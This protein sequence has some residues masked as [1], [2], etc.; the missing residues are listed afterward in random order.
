MPSPIPSERK[1]AARVAAH[2]RW[3]S[4]DD[5]AE[6]TR[7]AR[8]AF[9]ARFE[10]QADPDGL[11]TPADKERRAQHLASAYF[12]RLSLASARARRGAE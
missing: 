7:P 8:E 3:A 1:L 9:M 10:R 5:R 6:A 2:T 11:L 4:I 12:A